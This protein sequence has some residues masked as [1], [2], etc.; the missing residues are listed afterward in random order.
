MPDDRSE[1]K[2]AA[3]LVLDHAR[4]VVVD[5]LRYLKFSE[6]ADALSD[7]PS[8][9]ALR[10][11][12][13]QV[14][15]TLHDWIGFGPKRRAAAGAVTALHSAALLGLRGD[16]PSAAVMSLGAITHAARARAWHRR[17]WQ[18]LWWQ[19]VRRRVLDQAR[20]EQ[21]AYLGELNKPA[22]R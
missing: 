3:R 6:L 12:A 22:E 15:N 10:H 2:I 13:P 18:L 19:R 16:A 17:P 9:S 11:V 1:S 14:T 20:A 4:P 8:L 7:A 21:A 5:M